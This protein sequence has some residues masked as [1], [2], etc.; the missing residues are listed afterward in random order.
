[1]SLFCNFFACVTLETVN[2]LKLININKKYTI[3][4]DLE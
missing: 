3:F 1:M 2:A 4:F